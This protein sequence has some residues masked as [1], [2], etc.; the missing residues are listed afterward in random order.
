MRPSAHWAPPHQSRSSLPHPWAGR[1]GPWP[2][3]GHQLPGSQAAPHSVCSVAQ[4]QCAGRSDLGRGG[5]TV[6]PDRGQTRLEGSGVPSMDIGGG[7]RPEPRPV[8][9]GGTNWPCRHSPAVE[10]LLE[11]WIC[12]TKQA[13]LGSEEIQ[14]VGPQILLLRLTRAFNPRGT[15]AIWSQRTLDSGYKIH[16]LRIFIPSGLKGQVK[17]DSRISDFSSESWDW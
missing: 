15:T 5:R 11:A 3:R 17:S 8:P 9:P 6:S 10:L 4:W 1:S 16:K 13:A 12:R 2:G 7:C 14:L